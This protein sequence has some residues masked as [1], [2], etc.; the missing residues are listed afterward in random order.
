[1]PLM[2]KTYDSIHGRAT[3]FSNFNLKPAEPQTGGT[4]EIHTP[5]Q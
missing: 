2:K 5:I 1:M 3:I 4:V